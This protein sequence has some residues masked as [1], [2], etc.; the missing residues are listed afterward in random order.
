MTMYRDMY[1]L[2]IAEMKSE[3]ILNTYLA[4]YSLTS[5]FFTLMEQSTNTMLVSGGT[6]N[7][8]TVT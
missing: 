4:S 6:E 1:G 3:I 2:S 7:P 5:V 8:E